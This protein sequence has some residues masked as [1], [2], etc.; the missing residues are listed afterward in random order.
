[1]GEAYDRKRGFQPYTSRKHFAQ[2]KE[3]FSGR[4]CYCDEPLQPGHE[5]Q[6]HLIPTNRE[7]LGLHSWGNV[8]PACDSCNAK[9]QGR[10]WHAYLA[11]C[12]GSDSSERYK[13][14]SSFIQYYDYSP[15]LADLR[16]VA[17]DLYAE[18]GAIAMTL[19][20][21]K[22]SRLKAEL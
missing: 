22:I 9:K 16:A 6:D 14:I 11:D 18:V 19:I 2:I 10:E 7:H 13:R 5:A 20:E 21:S 12:A 8:V 15:D 1:M 17:A 3:F 4:C